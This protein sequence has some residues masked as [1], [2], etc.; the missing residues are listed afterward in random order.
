MLH[1]IVADDVTPEALQLSYRN[2]KLL[3]DRLKVNGDAISIEKF[4]DC[5]FNK[6]FDGEYVVTFDD[7]YES[8]YQYAFPFLKVNNIPFTLFVN[9]SLL[10]TPKYITTNQLVEMANT[11]LCTIGSHGMHHVFFR[12]LTKDKCKSELRESKVTLE[13]IINKPVDF[14]AFPYG[15]LVACSF[16]NIKEVKKSD[17][18]MSFLTIP[19]GVW[20]SPIINK[21]FLPRINVTKKIIKRL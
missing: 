11:E 9:L 16:N 10:D 7:V 1:E 2:F 20:N 14:F 21:Y 12:N 3:V 15:S 18:K 13:K 4:C 8:V 6:K 19:S 17:Y 5:F